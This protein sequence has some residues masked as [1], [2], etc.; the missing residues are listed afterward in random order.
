M[1][2]LAG[3]TG[4]EIFLYIGLTVSFLLL[5]LAAYFKIT[6][7]L[8]LARPPQRFQQDRQLPKYQKERRAGIAFSRLIFKYIPPF[9]IGFLLLTIWQLW[10]N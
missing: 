10:L 3:L 6:G 1:E 8:F 2:Q 9:F 4:F 5:F 7:G